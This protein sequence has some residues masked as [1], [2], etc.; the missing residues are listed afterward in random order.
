MKR[1]RPQ[2]G[3]TA[4]TL[5]E[6]LS[7]MAIVAI[8]A[9][10][11]LPALSKVRQRALRVECVDHL[12]QVGIAFHNF[13]HDHNNQFPM[14][15]PI[16]AGGSLE[17]AQASARNPNSLLFGYHHFQ[18]LANDLGSPRVLVCPADTRPPA[19]SF[20]ALS[21]TN[22]SYFVAL[23]SSF[24]MSG[25][26]L[27]GDRNVTNA[28]IEPSP[29]MKLGR[30]YGLT[31]TAELHQFKGNLLFADGRVEQ[32]NTPGLYA[33]ANQTPPV[34]DIV[35]PTTGSTR[36]PGGT[37]E[38]RRGPRTPDATPGSGGPAQS[39]ASSP[40]GT[41]TPASSSPGSAKFPPAGGSSPDQAGIRATGE[42]PEPAAGPGGGG[43]AFSSRSSRVTP[44]QSGPVKG[45]APQSPVVTTN[46]EPSSPPVSPTSGPSAPPSTPDTYWAWFGQAAADLVKK[47]MWLLYLL[48][49]LFA[50]ALLFLRKRFRSSGKWPFRGRR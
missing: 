45:P 2:C 16:A 40:K 9:A 33:A 47:G 1:G 36:P 3:A 37:G 23:N 15:V 43:S 13:A 7:V 20:R 42:A 12:R 11:L 32:P 5:I 39:S 24:G 8:L 41:G 46:S 50:I 10:L 30:N 6:L 48:L 49:V 29:V 14:Q 21:N 18:A 38:P 17:Y 22:L 27:A 19:V 34:I 26:I 28:W 44:E 4:F 25:A 35:I 31:W